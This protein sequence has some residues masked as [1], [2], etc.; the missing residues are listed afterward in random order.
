MNNADK[1]RSMNNEE[2]AEFLDKICNQDRD[3]WSPIGCG[4]S[5]STYGTHHY[6]DDCED[7]EFKDG[8]LAWLE[9]E[10]K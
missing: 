7:C 2:L 9:N 8:I 6:P 1:I 3:D 4:Y 5:C 10:I